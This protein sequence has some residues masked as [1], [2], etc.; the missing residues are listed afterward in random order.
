MRYEELAL[1]PTSGSIDH[2]AIT[3][4]LAAQPHAFLHQWEFPIWHLCWD[5]EDVED[6]KESFEQRLPRFGYGA[7]VIVFSDHI[8]VQAM[9]AGRCQVR[10]LEFLRWLVRDGAWLVK[11]DWSDRFEPVGDPARLFPADTEAPHHT[12]SED[13]SEGVRHEW[14]AGER[15]FVVHSSGQFRAVLDDRRWWQGFLTPTALAEWNA[16]VAALGFTEEG[17]TRFTDAEEPEGRFDI[18]TA[19]EREMMLFDVDDIP[20]PLFPV[21][22]LIGRWLGLLANWDRTSPSPIVQRL[23]DDE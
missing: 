6:A 12:E 8:S 18:E 23:R 16:A 21:A 19:D 20:P 5:A 2:Q 10:A 7:M 22:A 1:R 14:S 9:H 4:W 3:A 17:I 11:L 13:V 15:Q